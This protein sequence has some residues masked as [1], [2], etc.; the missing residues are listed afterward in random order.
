GQPNTDQL[1][2][3]FGAAHSLEKATQNALADMV[4]KLPVTV[5]TTTNFTNVKTNDKVYQ[6]L[7]QQITS[8]TTQI[9]FPNY[10][11]INH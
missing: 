11:V 3:G 9:T 2:D 10:K 5:S 8:R 4:Q 6:K 1:L 7:T